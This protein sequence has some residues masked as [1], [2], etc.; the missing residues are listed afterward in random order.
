MVSSDFSH[1]SNL[2][3]W[4]GKKGRVADRVR[5][6][7]R[8]EPHKDGGN[9]KRT[10]H[11]PRLNFYH[12]VE[13]ELDIKLKVSSGGSRLVGAVVRSNAAGT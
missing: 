9:N 3:I 12:L 11:A 4:R 5:P 7:Q 13:T 1:L 10:P 2:E 8:E 6:F